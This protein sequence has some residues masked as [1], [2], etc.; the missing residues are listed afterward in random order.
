MI[1]L[2][3]CSLLHPH[4]SC[5]PLALCW[6]HLL[7]KAAQEL[8]VALSVWMRAKLRSFANGDLLRGRSHLERVLAAE[9]DRK[10]L[11]DGKVAVP[12]AYNGVWWWCSPVLKPEALFSFSPLP[13]TH[14]AKFFDVV[15][16]TTVSTII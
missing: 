13:Q 5:D 14:H 4:A 3:S 6:Q 8:D 11:L 1:F 12:C 15:A 10:L 9:F 7:R 16:S 2:R